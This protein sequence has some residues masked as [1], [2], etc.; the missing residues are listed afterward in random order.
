MTRRD[1]SNYRP[2]APR[3]APRAPY[4]REI[5]GEVRREVLRLAANGASKMVIATTLRL[6]YAAVENI[7]KRA[8][9]AA[10]PFE[11]NTL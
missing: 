11:G 10:C 8:A 9:P 2:M 7:L 4:D 6:R 1:L 3:K 5:T